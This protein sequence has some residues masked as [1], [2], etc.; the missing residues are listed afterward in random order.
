VQDNHSRSQKNTIRGLHYQVNPGQGKLIRVLAG[1]IFDIAV[2]IR[3]GSP[4][5]G[6]WFGVELSAENKKQF[7]IPCGFGHGFC[8]FSET[9]DV[10]YKCTDFYSPENERGIMW[11][12]PALNIQWPVEE[13]LLSDRDC[14]HPNFTDI[15]RDFTFKK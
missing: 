9:A 14:Q 2:D 8:V 11:N 3:F 4:T 1:S 5:F 13:P 15:E 6:Q 10:E 7:W 12:D